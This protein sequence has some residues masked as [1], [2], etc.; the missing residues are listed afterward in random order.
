MYTFYVSWAVLLFCVN[1][2]LTAWFSYLSHAAYAMQW[3]KLSYALGLMST[4]LI[5][6]L[7]TIIGVIYLLI[8]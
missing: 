2:S 6:N 7:I 4:V 8:A 3:K 5:Y 1:I